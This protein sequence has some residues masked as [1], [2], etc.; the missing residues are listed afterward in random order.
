VSLVYLLL[1]LASAELA[2][3]R[4]AVPTLQP[5][6]HAPPLWHE[7]LSYAGLFLLYFA[8]TL[9]VGVLLAKLW[10]LVR[11]PERAVGARAIPAWGVVAVGV[12]FIALAI[13]NIAHDPG[14]KMSFAFD[15]AF[16]LLLLMLVVHLALAPGDLWTRLGVVA[17]CVPLVIHYYAPFRLMFIDSAE[18]RWGDLPL[19]MQD[20]GKWTTVATANLLPYLFIPKPPYSAILRP[21]PL[22]VAAF[23]TVVGA[24]ILRQ[25]FEVGMELASKGMGIEISAGE[26][27]SHIALYV[28]ALGALAWTVV[29]CV[30]APA[31]AR[32]DIGVGLGLVVIGGYGF[33]WPLQY[34]CSAAGLFTIGE[35]A[36]AVRAQELALARAPAARSFRPPPIAADSWQRWITALVDALRELG[37]GAKPSSVTVG[38]DGP[39]QT[40]HVL[41]NRHD[42][43]VQLRVQRVRDGVECIDVICG[44]PPP[45]GTAPAWTLYARPQR[46]GSPGHD[47]PPAC[48]GAATRTGDAAFDE[49]FRVRDRGEIT[50]RLLD[51]DLRARA[52]ALVD[53]WIACWPDVALEYRV[54]PGRGAPLDSPIAITQLAFRGD[55][56]APVERTV[57]LLELLAEMAARGGLTSA[58]DREPEQLGSA[59]E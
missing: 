15:S 27:T 29:A 8:S 1:L 26:P 37:P 31:L 4:L 24:V 36:R 6:G 45:A 25:H 53:G 17:L 42:V 5:H 48:S 49:R 28:I 39:V 33:D 34:L 58:A 38:G 21:A 3:N 2:V 41:V 57:R 18:A 55:Q 20:W 14:E 59:E 7:V 9:A 12:A 35:A 23:V 10:H 30:S 13:V 16:T 51:D 32:R 46:F 50:A 22:A 47:E 43:S 40:T 54:Y 52:T 19:T 56:P 44:R 11:G